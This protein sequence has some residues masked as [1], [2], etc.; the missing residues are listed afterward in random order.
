MLSSTGISLQTIVH[1][2]CWKINLYYD[3]PKNEVLFMFLR[4]QLLKL[5]SE[6]QINDALIGC[7][8]NAKMYSYL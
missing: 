6:S 4:G 8:I 2:C 5:K 1:V 7:K 3:F